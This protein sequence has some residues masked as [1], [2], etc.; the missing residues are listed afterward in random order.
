MVPSPVP[1][2]VSPCPFL[3]SLTFRSS[4]ALADRNL[5][6]DHSFQPALSVSV[7]S[8]PAAADLNLLLLPTVPIIRFLFFG[9]CLLCYLPYPDLS[10]P[11]LLSATTKRSFS[12]LSLLTIFTPPHAPLGLVVSSSCRLVSSLPCTQPSWI[13][14]RKRER[15]RERNRETAWRKDGCETRRNQDNPIIHQLSCLFGTRFES[16]I[17]KRP[18]DLSPR[19]CLC[20]AGQEQSYTPSYS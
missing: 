3:P 7:C 17:Q 8:S 16:S 6:P 14:R 19:T 10:S 11:V 15:K 5:R 18:V 9:C 12:F 1:V 13:R 4:N 20:V 2:L